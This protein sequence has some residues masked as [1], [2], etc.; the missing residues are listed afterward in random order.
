MKWI[1]ANG[2]ESSWG[3]VITFEEVITDF[4]TKHDIPNN[5]TI[6]TYI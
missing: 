3:L 5:W 2:G 1:E 4:T 6:Q